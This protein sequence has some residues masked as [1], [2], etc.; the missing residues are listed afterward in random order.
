MQKQYHVFNA[1]DGLVTHAVVTDN[2]DHFGVQLQLS[3]KPRVRSVTSGWFVATARWHQSG[4][5]R[6]YGLNTQID[7]DAVPVSGTSWAFGVRKTHPV[8]WYDAQNQGFLAATGAK[9]DI[10]LGRD[11]WLLIVDPLA[12][13]IL[14]PTA[15]TTQLSKKGTKA[16]L[17]LWNT[18]EGLA[19]QLNA[20]ALGKKVRAVRLELLRSIGL[21]DPDPTREVLAALSEPGS[22]SGTTVPFAPHYRYAFLA[23]GDINPTHLVQSV[24]FHKATHGWILCDAGPAPPEGSPGIN[25]GSTGYRFEIVVDRAMRR[26]IRKTVGVTPVY[27]S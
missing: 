13:Y 8:G 11:L 23:R 19:W 24:P 4:A 3:K 17:N 27:P 2:G 22:F 9:V 21:P 5:N 10:K 20:T 14:Q 18:P 7:G 6:L 1:S 15:Q 25:V 12:Q 16:D 26:D